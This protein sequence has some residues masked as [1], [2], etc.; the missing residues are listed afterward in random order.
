MVKTRVLAIVCAFT[1]AFSFG[2]TSAQAEE[3]D[4]WWE[5]D[6]W[7][8][9]ELIDLGAVLP[10]YNATT[11]QYEISMPEQLFFLS[12]AWKPEDSNG[13]GAPD[14][15][16]DGVYVLT[17]D[18]DM[19][20]LM[21]SIGETLSTLSG[22]EKEGYMPP[23]AARTDETQEGGVNCAFFGTFDGQ[24]H[25][26]SNL[27]IE[28]MQ[29]KYAGLFGNIG[30]D[31]G[32][33]FVKNLALVNIEVKCL[34]SCGLLVGGLYGDAENCVVIGTIDCQEKTAGGLAGKIKKNDNGYS[35]TASNCFVYADITVR[36][37]GD[38]N[39]AA[40]GVTSA[41]SDGGRIY[42]CYVGGSIT[43]L[44]EKAESVGGVTG[45]LKSGQAI[46]NTIM[47]LSDIDVADGTNIG[48]LCGNYS[49]ETGSHLVNDYV[50]DGTR[51]SGCVSSDHPEAAAFTSVDA[52]TILTKSF[53]SDTL[54]WDFDTLWSWVGDDTDGYPMLRQFTGS[55]GVLEGL[56]AT[57]A[58]DLTLTKAVLRPTEPMTTTAYAG[59]EV[60]ITCS[61]TLPEGASAGSAALCY[62]AEKDGTTFTDTVEM[63]DNGDGTYTA[64]FPETEA[65]EYYYYL[66]AVVG[67]TTLTF[68]SQL[69]SCIRLELVSPEAK[70]QPKQLTVSPGA[71]P[72]AVGMSWITETSE[73]SAKLLYRLAGGS[74][75]TTADVTEIYT[76]EIANGH[77][78]VTSYSVD[79]TGLTPGTQYE[80]RAVTINGTDEYPAETETFTTLPSGD[81]FSCILVSDLQA[82]AEEG[83]LPFLYTMD[84][85]VAD[86]LGGTDFV[87]SLGDMTED[88][89]SLAQW[90]YMFKTLGEYF[91]T[92]LN[93]FVAG[94]H[95]N[96]GDLGYTIFKAETNL[97]GGAD[98]PAL[99]E[100]TGSF[101]VGDVCFVM[102][103]TDPY[104]NTD[105]ADVVADKVAYYEAE[106][107]Y[108][109]QAFEVSGCSWRVIV[110]HAGLIQ[111]D[112]TATAFLEQMCDDL[113][114][115]LY[116]NGHIHDYYRATVRNGEAAET[117]MGTTFITT[118]PMGQKFDDFEE[119]V[120]DD[121]LQFQTGGSD[122]QRQYFTQIQASEDGLVVTAYQLTQ[123]GDVSKASSFSNYTAIDTIT[124]TTSL[125]MQRSEA[126]ADATVVT[127]GDTEQTATGSG[128]WKV[129]V[130]GVAA[131]AVVAAVI[132]IARKSKRKPDSKA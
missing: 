105:G 80:Y 23:I 34:A 50:W 46:E 3:A 96:S 59:D 37:E 114:V 99:D 64:V 18:L 30:H 33:G 120:I 117:G 41:Q 92:H 75:W 15:P 55:G 10:A 108:A 119:G 47:L 72:T 65:G 44:G 17:A 131:L 63:T 38:E 100:T 113:D 104:S 81:T 1:L 8:T 36:G 67:G 60:P 49:G 66:K 4:A 107:A 97:P 71:D 32:E 40:G 24:G 43:V 26:V 2:I 86:T 79:L 16:C 93:A 77:G 61:I 31:Y 130:V 123:P 42:N 106:E 95:E 62:G 13:D 73:L 132:L 76:G 69:N 98:D 78:N 74:E 12:G 85:F 29:H 56:L 118:S 122:D 115:D 19:Q 90:R 89:S 126:A 9:Q 7:E 25:V 51:F 116:F 124:L 54:G 45:D 27:R 20:P 53:Y 57:V 87:I 11:Q 121:L 5:N 91:A 14:A 112:P 110:A 68:P 125:S 83:Y 58:S 35:G 103:N 127:A 101:V 102:L 6:I 82:T 109:K 39:G 22:T 48:L 94:N 129:A 28:Q 88:G 128:W 52:A 21:D 70:Y 111:D 84:S